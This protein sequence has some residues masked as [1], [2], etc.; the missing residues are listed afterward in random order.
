MPR[1]AEIAVP[2]GHQDH[3]ITQIF[4]LDFCFLKDNNICFENVEHSLEPE[5]NAVRAQLIQAFAYIEGPI[6]SPWL[7]AEGISAKAQSISKRTTANSYIHARA[8]FH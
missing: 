4:S 3:I 2:A 6:I 7:I 5:I 8:L 1:Q